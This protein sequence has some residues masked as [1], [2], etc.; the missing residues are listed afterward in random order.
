MVSGVCDGFIGNRMIEQYARQAG[1]LLEEGALPA[2]GGQ[3][4]REV[5]L[6]DG[7]VP[8]GRPGRQRHRLGDP[9]APLRGAARA[10]LQPRSPTCCARWAAS[11][12]RP[13]P[14]GTATSPASATRFPI[15]V[16]DELIDDVPQGARH[17]A[18]QDQRR[19]DRRALRVRAGQRR[20]AH[21]RGGHRAARLATSTWSTSPATASRCTAAARCCY[22]DSVGLS[23]VVRAMKRFA[24]NPRDEPRS[25]SPRRC[26]Q[27]CR[28]RQDR[29]R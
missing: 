14:A 10:A 26:C 15:P 22:A 28:R 16:V 25:G 17:H 2:A 11:A 18:A 9:Q 6:R 13:A 20:R 8:H 29:S 23:N 12:R 24:A 5:R 4:D 3:G 27:R 19:R 1:F 7:P 21:P